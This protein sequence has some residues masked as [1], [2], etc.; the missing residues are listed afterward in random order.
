[1]KN[2]I[3]IT[4]GIITI[5]G[6]GCTLFSSNLNIDAQDCS[7]EWYTLVERRLK[8]SDN[9]GH[10]P[11]LGSI[12]WRSVIEFKLNI[13]GKSEVPPRESDLWCDYINKQ[14]IDKTEWQE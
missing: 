9:N 7:R 6:V 1:M 12:E 2:Y 5:S 4:I 14:L 11:D 10:G 3:K 8:T 13:R